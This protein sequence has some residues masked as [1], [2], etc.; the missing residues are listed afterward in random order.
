MLAQ[1]AMKKRLRKNEKEKPRKRRK[2]VQNMIF[3]GFECTHCS[4]DRDDDSQVR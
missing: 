4:Q 1:S 3:Y 2:P